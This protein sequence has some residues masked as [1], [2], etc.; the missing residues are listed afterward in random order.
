[1]IDF[2]K[3]FYSY[4]QK[5]PERSLRI[6]IYVSLYDKTGLFPDKREVKTFRCLHRL[7]GKSLE[8]LYSGSLKGCKEY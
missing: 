3:C 2:L 7:Q 5:T 4:V 1:M 6:F 8:A